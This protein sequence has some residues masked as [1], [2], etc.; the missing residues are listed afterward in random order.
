MI[1]HAVQEHAFVRKLPEDE[2]RI[3][4]ARRAGVPSVASDVQ[5]VADY[6]GLASYHRDQKMRFELGTS[7]PWL[8]VTPDS[9]SPSEDELSDAIRKWEKEN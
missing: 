1:Y 9:G 3:E 5:T 2:R 6:R 8:S 4:E 7:R